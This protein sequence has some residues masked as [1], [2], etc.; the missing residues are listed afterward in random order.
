LALRRGRYKTSHNHWE[1]STNNHQLVLML[2]RC[3]KQSRWRQPPRVTRISQP[4]WSPSATRCNHSSKY[5]RNHSQSHYDDELMMEISG[6]C[7]LRLTRMSNMS[8]CQEKWAK[9]SQAQFIEPQMNR[10]VIPLHWAMHTDRTRP[11][12][13]SNTL[14]IAEMPHVPLQTC[15]SVGAQRLPLTFDRMHRLEM[16]GRTMT[17]S[18]VKSKE[19]PEPLRCDR[20]RSV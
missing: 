8:K 12:W 6:R 1:T 7:L 11:V 2:L 10:A 3:S 20:T 19:L 4:Q 16:I 18:S 14:V 15:T 5:T 9:A 17:Q 13:R